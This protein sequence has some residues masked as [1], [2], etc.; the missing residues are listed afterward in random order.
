M[1]E[2]KYPIEHFNTFNEFFIREINP[3]A[4]PIPYEDNDHVVVYGTDSRLMAFQSEDDN[5]HSG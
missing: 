5:N 4:Q 3:G 1:D 2:F